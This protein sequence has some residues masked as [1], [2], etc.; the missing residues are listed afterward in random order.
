MLYSVYLCF[1]FLMI[2]RP[3]SSTRTDT[4]FP[5]TTL[6]R[7]GRS[8]RKGSTPHVR[9]QPRG[10]HPRQQQVE[11]A[12]IAGIGA[13]V[14]PPLAADR[15]QRTGPQLPDMR[16]VALHPRLR[17]RRRSAETRTKRGRKRARPEARPFLP[18]PVH[19]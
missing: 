6:F 11:I 13:A 19:A 1:F 16:E 15:L 18:A 7:S 12:P 5:Y 14:Q 8:G 17:H 10:V 3:P 2:R 4:L 9:D